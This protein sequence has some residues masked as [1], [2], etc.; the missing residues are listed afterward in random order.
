MDLDHFTVVNDLAGHDAGD[1]ALRHVARLLESQVRQLGWAARVGG[2]DL[3]WCCQVAP[4]REAGGGRATA[5][6]G[7]GLGTVVPGQQ[8]HPQ[9]EYWSGGSGCVHADVASVLYAADMACY[10]AK[11]AGRN[12]GT[13]WVAPAEASPSGRVA[14]GRPD[15][16]SGNCVSSSAPVPL[17]TFSAV[18]EAVNA[19]TGFAGASPLRPRRWHLRSA[20]YLIASMKGGSPTALLPPRC[21]RGWPRATDPPKCSGMSPVAGIL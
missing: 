19:P 10:D 3:P 16:L 21:L 4:W 11:R 1:D 18:A 7:A 2:D 17:S 20:S 14:L 12:P 9:H 8:L 13:D 6:G 15:P 5:P